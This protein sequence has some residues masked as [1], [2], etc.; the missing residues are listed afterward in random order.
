MIN[1]KNTLKALQRSKLTMELNDDEI[2]TLFGLLTVHEYKAGNFIV[3]PGE[4][5]LGDALLILIEGKIEVKAKVDNEPMVMNLTEPGDLARI[6]SFVGSNIT[7]IDAT[8]KVKEDCVVLLLE[9]T[10]LETLLETHHLIV[11]R[12]MRG[13]VRYMHSL[14]RRKSA[15]TEEMSNYFYRLNGLF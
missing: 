4:R 15:E 3:K 5:P 13:L 7:V 9:R 2:I 12:V 14:A 8:I 11:Y 1:D 6:I 10:K